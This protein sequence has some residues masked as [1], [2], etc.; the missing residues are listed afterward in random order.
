MKG[1]EHHFFSLIDGLSSV[2]KL[3]DIAVGTV[4]EK[5]L[6]EQSV[7]TLLEHQDLEASSVFLLLDGQ[8]RCAVAVDGTTV[9][10]REDARADSAFEEI[11]F[12]VGEG[13]VGMACQTG[14]IQYCPNCQNEETFRQLK[15]QQPFCNKGSMLS[16][17]MVSGGKRLG[18]LNVSH[19][20]PDFFEMWHQHMLSLYAHSLGRLLHLHRLVHNLE[21]S[22]RLRTRELELALE[23]SENLRRRYQQL[24]IKDELTGL[25]NRRY[26]FTEGISMLSRAVRYDLPFSLIL[27]DIDHFKRVND[28]LGHQVGDRA[29][30]MVAQVLQNEIRE[31]DLATRI[32]GEEFVMVLSN[33]S[34]IGTDLVARRI[35][36]KVAS[37]ELVPKGGRDALTVSIGM[38]LLNNRG[39]GDLNGLLDLLYQQ[40]DT[41]MYQCKKEGRNCRLFYVPSMGE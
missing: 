2:S 35:Q 4:S 17:P 29:L 39:E 36:E 10:P 31:G 28:A 24:S 11:Q 12:S 8:L 37:L 6:L 1:L 9:M 14:E 21:G 30:R 40:A 22:V 25:F 3:H 38:T 13:I 41:A 34:S 26:F 20:L 23:D 33:T 32:G 15:K 5:K 16:L 7:N 18:V 19:H 27:I